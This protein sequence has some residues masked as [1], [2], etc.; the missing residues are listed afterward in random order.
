MF[1]FSLAVGCRNIDEEDDLNYNNS[2]D[3]INDSINDPNDNLPNASYPDWSEATHSNDVEPNF[4]IVFAQDEVMRINITIDSADWDA[5]WTD[6]SSNFGSSGGGGGMV[7][8]DGMI[9][10]GPGGGMPPG[11]GPGGDMM[12]PG[13][14][15]GGAAAGA[16]SYEPMWVPC[17]INFN[18]KDWYEVG[19]RFKGNSSLSSTYSSGNKKLSLKL[20]FDQFEDDNP[21]LKNQRFYGFKQLNLNNNYNDL[22]LMRDKVA[23]DLFRSFGLA[24]AHSAFY[25]VYINDEYYGVY[26]L[27]EEVDN[28]VIKTQFSD[29]SG[30]LYK[31][32]G[33]ASTFKSG[34]YDTSELY[35]KTNTSEPDYS[36]AQA[37][38]DVINSAERTSNPS[39]W[40]EDLEN[41][42]DVDA[43]LKWLAANAVIQNW[44][45]YGMMTHN[46]YIYN[47]MGRLTWIPWDNNEAFKSGTGNRSSIEIDK[48]GSVSSSWPLISYIYGVAEYEAQYK[49]YLK[50]FVDEHF[51]TAQMQ[52][53]YDEY[54]NLL[55]SY[56]E[57]E[58]SGKSFFNNPASEF[59]SAVS[60]LKSHVQSRTTTV[61]N[62][63]N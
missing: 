60:T 23:A 32:E 58:V 24:A 46:Y 21:S 28:T 50:E 18:D 29:G 56:A 25:T 8:D 51:V 35:L 43:F 15:M 63:V 41:V 61:N 34:S 9:P 13:G 37:L 10:E 48:M 22:A 26:T 38:Y 39:A 7:P 44:D 20:D 1:V 45:T 11:G 47:Y 3:S 40:Q 54:Y 42:F 19:V 27:L 16:S 33:D 30:N 59:S 6:L 17:T 31:P 49:T 2:S 53:L 62:F 5:M 12:P 4:D 55:K 36:D 57:A 52:A 14:D